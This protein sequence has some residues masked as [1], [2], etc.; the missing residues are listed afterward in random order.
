[1]AALL[2]GTFRARFVHLYNEVAPVDLPVD[3]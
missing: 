2:P 3:I 1:M